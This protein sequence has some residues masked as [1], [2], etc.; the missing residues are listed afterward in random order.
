MKGRPVNSVEEN[1]VQAPCCVQLTCM[2]LTVASWLAVVFLSPLSLLRLRLGLCTRASRQR[3]TGGQHVC[4][5]SNSA[6]LSVRHPSRVG[7]YKPKL[8]VGK[9]Q[10]RGQAHLLRLSRLRLRD[11]LD[12]SLERSLLLDLLRSLSH[13]LS[14]PIING[15][16]REEGWV[17]SLVT[18]RVNSRQC[19]GM[20]V[21]VTSRRRG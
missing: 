18:L 14:L 15:L 13:L 12:L 20:T 3:A 5:G 11:R 2:A 16:S 6:W 1:S 7:R 4:K 10:M 8:R 19:N 9:R 17:H 21:E